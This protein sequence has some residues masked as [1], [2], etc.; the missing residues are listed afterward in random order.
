MRELPRVRRQ[1]A[2]LF[3]FA[4]LASV[5][6]NVLM[7]TGPLFM[8]QVYDRVL[9]SRSEETLLA[10][11]ILV[12]FLFAIMGVLEWSR[13]RVLARAGARFQARLDGRVFDA[14]LR[15]ALRPGARNRPAG[16]MAD[17][18]AIRQ[19]LSSPVLLALFDMPFTPLFAALIFAFHP[20][21]GWL[22]LG[23]G[24]LLIVL[25]FLNQRLTRARQLE[26]VEAS[27]RAESLAGQARAEAESVLGMGMQAAVRR[28]WRALRDLALGRAIAAADRTGMFAAAIKS[29]RL[30]LQ[31]AMLGLGAWLVL[32]N[33]I[34]SGAMIAAS[35]LL[36]RSLAP[37][38]QSLGNWPL[39]QR[40]FAGWRNLSRVLEETPP[41]RPRTALPEPKAHLKVSALSVVPPGEQRPALAGVSFELKP[42]QALGVIGPSAAGKST[43]ARAITGVWPVTAGR[44]DLDGAAIEQYEPA[45]LG[46]HVGYLPQ[47]IT[48]FRGTIAENIARMSPEPDQEAVV[49]A[50]MAAGAHEA[51]KALPRGYDTEISNDAR[52][53]GGQRQLVGL[54]RALYGAPKLLVLDEPNSNLDSFG[55][56][57]VN[58]A[59]RSLKERGGAVVIIAHRPAAIAEC[60]LLLMLEAGRQKAFGPRDE[61]LKAHVRNVARIRPGL[62]PAGR[63]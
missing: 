63:A 58:G 52:L 7:L 10:L 38:E 9:G 20:A 8:L 22:A 44:I 39:A 49:A 45:V 16:E 54:A 51:I 25:S 6:V 14:V 13:S 19:F 11:G 31:S 55:S 3:V 17:L 61:V 26:A 46:R 15:G 43:L 18:E 41:E 47:A 59:V 32:G 28:R 2:G 4:A 40:A 27:A 60:E 53:S 12:A 5:V 62:K 23:G 36:G 21:L 24:G 33:E 30:F 37:I 57:M 48:L 29:F 42:G 35:I 50:A 34:T 56:A 1:S